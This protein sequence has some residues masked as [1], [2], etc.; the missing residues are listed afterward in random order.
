MGRSRFSAP[1]FSRSPSAHAPV[2]LITTR[3]STS[4]DRVGPPL[5]SSITTPRTRP[6]FVLSTSVA[7]A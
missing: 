1:T 2:A 5:T 6:F 3:A 7:R 4:A